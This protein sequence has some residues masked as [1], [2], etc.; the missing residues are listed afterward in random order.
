VDTWVLDMAAVLC[1]T[2]G[3]NMPMLLV[4]DFY[5]LVDVYLDA[6]YHPKCVQ[7]EMTFMQEGWHYE[8]DAPEVGRQAFL[9]S[10]SYE[11]VTKYLAVVV[12]GFGTQHRLLGTLTSQKLS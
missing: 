9:V 6:V 3:C 2:V 4:Q 7:D 12:D 10:H 1:C 11:C 8:M 5:N